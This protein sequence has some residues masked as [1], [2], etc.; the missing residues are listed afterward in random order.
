MYLFH[1]ECSHFLVGVDREEVDAVHF[2]SIV[3]GYFPQIISEGRRLALSD[4]LVTCKVYIKKKKI[5]VNL[6]AANCF[7]P[8][9]SG[10]GEGQFFVVI[11]RLNLL[12][13]LQDVIMMNIPQERQEYTSLGYV[14]IVKYSLCHEGCFEFTT[15]CLR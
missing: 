9:P 8:F 5:L 15:I 10:M 14:C 13:Q 12:D 7:L 1:A 3:L 6:D 2:P 4:S 11:V